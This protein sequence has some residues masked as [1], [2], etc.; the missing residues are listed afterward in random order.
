MKPTLFELV[1]YDPT[2]TPRFLAENP[3][4]QSTVQY[5]DSLGCTHFFVKVKD[6]WP[7]P[8]R[9]VDRDGKKILEWHRPKPETVRGPRGG[10][11][12]GGL[13]HLGHP[14]IGAQ[15]LGRFGGDGD[16]RSLASHDCSRDGLGD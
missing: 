10:G 16:R 2:Y 8:R 5:L 11:V 15:P 3:G 14:A 9:I 4:F 7:T 6:S 1:I 13:L 12:T